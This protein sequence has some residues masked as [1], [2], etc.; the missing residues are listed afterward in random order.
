M[1]MFA[2]DT[3]LAGENREEINN[4]LDEW[5][6]AHHFLGENRL[7]ITRS[8]TGDLNLNLREENK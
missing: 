3:V 1:V 2:N 6:L 4:K 7:M 5:K 8:K